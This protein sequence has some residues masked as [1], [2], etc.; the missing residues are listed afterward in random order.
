MFLS[1]FTEGLGRLGT[2]SG[3]MMHRILS[4]EMR[5]T[6][7]KVDCDAFYFRVLRPYRKISLV[8][9]GHGFFKLR[10]PFLFPE[11]ISGS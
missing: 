4:Q 2:Q 6:R 1:K 8:E 7:K 10:Y 9:C 5:V 11:K 3:F